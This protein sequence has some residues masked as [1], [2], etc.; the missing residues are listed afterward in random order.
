MSVTSWQ[1]NGSSLYLVCRVF[2]LPFLTAIASRGEMDLVVLWQ[3]DSLVIT[4]P[5]SVCM[6]N[7]FVCLRRW[8]VYI[9]CTVENLFSY[10]QW[11]LSNVYFSFKYTVAASILLEDNQTIVWAGGVWQLLHLKGTCI[12]FF[13]AKRTVQNR[14]PAAFTSIATCIIADWC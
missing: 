11:C 9:Y 8:H 2:F 6:F 10:V 3:N 1:I 13:L 7:V 5:S 12:F 14:W 4:S